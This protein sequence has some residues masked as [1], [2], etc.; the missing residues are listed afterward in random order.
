VTYKPTITT[1]PQKVTVT[2]TKVQ[3]TVKETAY[4]VEPRLITKIHTASCKVPR[5][6]QHP[7]PTCSITPTLVKAAALETA[8]PT[9]MRFMDRSVPLAREQRIA[10]RKARLAEA[11]VLEK[12]APDNAT[13]TV[14]DT[15]T[16]RQPTF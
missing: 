14:T 15:N 13:V 8:S 16:V 2:T 9:A 7:D 11:R 6:Q 1:T 4:T 3:G 12:R 10:E 5:K